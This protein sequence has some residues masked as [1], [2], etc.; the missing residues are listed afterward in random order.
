MTQLPHAGRNAY[1]RIERLL[2]RVPGL[3]LR[4]GSDLDGIAAAI[5]ALLARDDVAIAALAR[6]EPN[7]QAPPAPLMSVII[8]VRDGAAF[9]AD[10]V[11]SIR[12]QN[13]PNLEIIVVDDGST[14]DFEGAIQALQGDIRQ[15]RMRDL[16]PAGARN[17]G[18]RNASGSLLAFLDVDDLW[19]DDRLSIMVERLCTAPGIDVLH[20]YSQLL[21]RGPAGGDW[22]YVGNP[23]ESFPHYIGAGLYRRTAFEN[24]GLFDARLRF[25]EDTDWFQRAEAA[26]LNVERLD[27]VTLLV[28]RHEHNMTRNRTAAELMP[29]LI[30][31]KMIERQRAAGTAGQETP[32]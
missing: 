7:K 11:A 8:P 4:L 6:P 25:G 20:G 1:E 18:I 9:I 16:G 5:A 15:F 3:R 17:V 12:R 31:K 19:P 29:L 21:Q 14:D 24:V 30:V 10:A 23:R 32:S 27:Q 13:Y 2:A 28:R 22:R 26:G